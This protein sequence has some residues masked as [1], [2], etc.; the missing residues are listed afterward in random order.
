MKKEEDRI[1]T[2]ALKLSTVKKLRSIGKMGDTIND[3]IEELLK[4]RKV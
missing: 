4:S 2:Q 3:V 1:I